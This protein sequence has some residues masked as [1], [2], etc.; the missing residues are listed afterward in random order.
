MTQ[1][2]LKQR[3]VSF[4]Q[5]PTLLFHFSF[6]SVPHMPKTKHWNSFDVGVAYWQGSSLFNWSQWLCHLLCLVSDWL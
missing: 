5:P 3:F 4:Q 2:R 1:I 6:V